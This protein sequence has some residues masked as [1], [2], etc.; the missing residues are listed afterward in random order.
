T[1]NLKP[2]LPDFYNILLERPRGDANGYGPPGAG[3]DLVHGHQQVVGQAGKLTIAVCSDRE[4]AYGEELTMDYCS[5][6]HSEEEYLAAV[7]LCGSHI[8]R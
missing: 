3:A 8:C 1:L 7:C 4:I 5:F 2:A 6:T